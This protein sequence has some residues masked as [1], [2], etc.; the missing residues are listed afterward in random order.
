MHTSISMRKCIRAVLLHGFFKTLSRTFRHPSIL[1]HRK[2]LSTVPNNDILQECVAP[3][4]T[5]Y[6]RIFFFLFLWFIIIINYSIIIITKLYATCVLGMY[7]SS[8]DNHYVSVCLNNK[9]S[10][11]DCFVKNKE[12]KAIILK[13]HTKKR[14]N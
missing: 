13:P 2:L 1:S 9:K 6:S 11:I 5:L 3:F 12:T 10:Y 7:R 14:F 8:V 4:N